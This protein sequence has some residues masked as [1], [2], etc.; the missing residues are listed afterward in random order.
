M[1]SEQQKIGLKL[2]KARIERGLNQAELGALVGK[3]STL[4][5]SLETGR[6]GFAVETL[7]RFATVLQKPLS[8]FYLWD[9]LETDDKAGGIIS[10]RT[11]EIKSLEPE[12]VV[13]K[14]IEKLMEVLEQRGIQLPS[15][16]S[17]KTDIEFMLEL[18]ALLPPDLQ[19]RI[20]TTIFNGTHHSSSYHASN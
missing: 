3:S 1:L 12:T 17:D 16:V 18:I 19:R 6:S 7:K 8:Y 15:K 13:E 11:E 10:K 20:V 14:I 5:S 4:V 2:R 9:D